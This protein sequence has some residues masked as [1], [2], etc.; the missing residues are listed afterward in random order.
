MM[1]GP[2][3]MRHRRQFGSPARPIARREHPRRHL[4]DFK[5]LLQA[6]GYAGFDRLYNEMC[7][8]ARAGPMPNDLT[9]CTRNSNRSGACR[10]RRGLLHVFGHWKREILQERGGYI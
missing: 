7:D 8:R 3:P 6:D 2:P 1:T 10:E 5:G 4:R 9:H